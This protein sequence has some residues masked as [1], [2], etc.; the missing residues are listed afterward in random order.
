MWA[1]AHQKA[2]RVRDRRSG[3]ESTLVPPYASDSHRASE[4]QLNW[5]EVSTHC[6]LHSTAQHSTPQPVTS[7]LILDMTHAEMRFDGIWFRGGRDCCMETGGHGVQQHATRTTANLGK[8]VR[9]LRFLVFGLQC[10]SNGI[11]T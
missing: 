2:A 4:Q 9:R 11:P 5:R 6:N 7:R 8:V 10:V 3:S 1:E